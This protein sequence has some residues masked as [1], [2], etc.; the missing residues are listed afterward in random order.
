MLEDD[1][2][3]PQSDV[4]HPERNCSFRMKCCRGRVFPHPDEVEECYCDEIRHGV[5]MRVPSILLRD[6]GD[7]GDRDS[8]L[9]LCRRNSVAKTFQQVG[10]GEVK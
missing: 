4:A 7:G 5:Q 2:L 8:K 10:D 1:T 6:C 3:T 9:G